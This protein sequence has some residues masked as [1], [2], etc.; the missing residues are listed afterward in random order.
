M[1]KILMKIFN[2]FSYIYIFIFE[3]KFFYCFNLILLKLV[4]K[5]IEYKI[6]EISILLEKE[7]L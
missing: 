6:L 4:L 2:F 5:S 7:N 3:R 1:K